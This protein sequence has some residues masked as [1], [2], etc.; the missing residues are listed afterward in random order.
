MQT[1]LEGQDRKIFFIAVLP[2]RDNLEKKAPNPTVGWGH[3][4]HDLSSACRPK[5]RILRP[6]ASTEKQADRLALI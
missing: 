4:T 2:A 5:Q 1:K 3:L 6:V